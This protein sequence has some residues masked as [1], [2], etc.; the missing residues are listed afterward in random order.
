MIDGTATQVELGGFAR[1]V[2]AFKPY[3]D[4]AD[5]I[6]LHAGDATTG[7][8]YYALFKGEADAAMM[9]KVCFDAMAV[10][11]HE[12]DDSDAQLRD[13]IDHLHRGECR[14]PVLAANITPKVGTPLGTPSLD[15]YIQPYAIKSIEGVRVAIIGLTVANK[16]MNS[17]RPLPTTVFND[18]ATAVQRVIDRLKADGVRRF[19]VLSH[20]GYEADLALAARLTDIDV[21]VGGDSHSLLGD[22]AMHG[23]GSSGPYPTLVKNKDGA[24]VCIVQ[25]W[26]YAKAIGEL[27]VAFNAQGEVENCTGKASLLVGSNFK[28]KDASG[29]FIPVD[30]GVREQILHSLAKTPSVRVVEPDVAATATLVG[31]ASQ[32]A[33]RMA[34]TIGTATEPL[35]LVRVPGESTNRSAAV[36]GCEAANKLARGSDIAQIVAEAFLAGSPAADV[37]L[38]NAGGVRTA[39]PA[40]SLN[41][42]SAFVLLPFSNVLVDMKLSGQQ[43][44]DVLEDAVAYHLAS[45]SGSGSH[46]YAAGLRWDLDMIKA[47]GARFS[48]M[49]IRDRKTAAWTPVDLT[50]IYSV[51]TSDFIASGKDGYPILG[52]LFARGDYVNNYRLYT[53]TFV[54]YVL[55][56]RA[57]ARPDTSDYSHQSVITAAGEKLR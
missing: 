32:V 49:E 26:E 15:A 10:G 29:K 46:P 38:Q 34:E 2:T 21:I 54:D 44:V 45:Q 56:K 51:V 3:A 53:Q 7:T 9:N 36:A 43:L 57:I 11:N 12:F 52:E 30:A 35:C 42:N 4:R 50:K 8:L 22:F 19:V 13:F 48:N 5:V 33:A 1:L 39:L 31:Y 23:V 41:M 14:T 16:T 25:A 18:E 24:P 17:S 20:Q 28:R 40:G 27:R 47:K 37:A 6:K 55:A